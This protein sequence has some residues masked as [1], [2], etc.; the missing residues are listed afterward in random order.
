MA[1]A[2]N[3]KACRPRAEIRVAESANALVRIMSEPGFLDRFEVVSFDVFDTLLYRKC[4]PEAVLQNIHRALEKRLQAV[5]LPLQ[6]PLSRARDL[7]Y[8]KLAAQKVAQGLDF[9]VGL[10]EMIPEWLRLVSGRSDLPAELAE[11]FWSTEI[12]FEKRSIFANGVFIELLHLCRERGKRVVFTSDMY[13]G[14]A[15]IET[16]LAE[17]GFEGFS[18]GYV[19]GD[20]C[21]LKRTGRLFQ[22]LLQ[23][24]GVAPDQ[25]LH[26]GDDRRADGE[27]AAAAGIPSLV[28]AF[29][30]EIRRRQALK[31]AARNYQ[32]GKNVAPGQVVSLFARN[33]YSALPV[34]QV[35]GLELLGPIFAPFI[36]RLLE[37]CR[38]EG[39]SRVYFVAR[40]G[41]LLKAMFDRLA[42]QVFEPGTE[43]Q[44]YYLCVSRLTSFLAS[45]REFTLR[46]FRYCHANNAGHPSLRNLFAPFG[47]EEGFLTERARLAGVDDI[48]APVRA[49]KTAEKLF[50]HPAIGRLLADDVFL[51]AIESVC[52][53]Q[54]KGL[55]SYLSSLDF[56]RPGDVALVDVGWS[57]QIQDNLY[58]AFCRD[59][60]LPRIWGMYLGVRET[61]TFIE[62]DGCRFEGLLADLSSP[63]WCSSAAF[64]FVQLFE[65]AARAPHGTVIGY[66]RGESSRYEPV[67]KADDS[68]SRRA[69]IND[70]AFLSGLQKG[71]LA[72]TRHYGE[73]ADMAGLPAAAYIPYA[74]M[75]LVRLVRKPATAEVEGFGRLSNVS[76]LGSDEVVRL[77]G[78]LVTAGEGL[79]LADKIKALK[80]SVWK[81]GTAHLLGWGVLGPALAFYRG[82]RFNNRYYGVPERKSFPPRCEGVAE[83]CDNR[84]NDPCGDEILRQCALRMEALASDS[85]DMRTVDRSGSLAIPT[86][87]E[88]LV[89]CLVQVARFLLFKPLFRG[90]L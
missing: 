31:K 4:A 70:E 47:L 23:N 83:T 12:D 33:G 50:A 38:E 71:I 27:M 5:G 53:K 42:P 21:L 25:V 35:F 60:T 82:V 48:D 15:C 90:F 41:F 18:A 84:R 45:V 8:R 73:F 36:H 28:L 68:P 7:A 40:E 3:G 80:V 16:I 54:K 78:A 1:S 14:R 10:Q 66:R 44:G 74:K 67:L 88:R 64:E 69:E 62:A 2:G 86:V 6:I 20:H 34:A 11:D 29:P 49:G 57:G 39:I 76:D 43:P 46:E 13:L 51:E 59:R 56:F 85:G 30:E 55:D 22:L 37:R 26:V 32:A 65:A 77:G 19:S 89:F 9:E 61:A 58:Q 75:M 81:Y 52:A 79:T 72:F 63:D 24:E 87:G 17:H